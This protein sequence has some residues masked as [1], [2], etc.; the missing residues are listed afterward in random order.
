MS[1]SINRV[2]LFGRLTKDP[3]TKYTPSGAAVSNFSL[4]LN[5]K[6]KD[7]SGNWVEKTEYVDVVLWTRL[8]EIAAEYLKKGDPCFI[9]GKLATRSWDDKTSGQKR[10]KTEVIGNELIL[11]GNGEKSTS[12]QPA[13][14]EE[15]AEVAPF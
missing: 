12:G 14:Q 13:T 6:Y 11:L 7:K 5:E 10:Y 3:A 9:E 1:R 15:E 8:A 4:A 2:T